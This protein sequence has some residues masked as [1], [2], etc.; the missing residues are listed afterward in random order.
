MTH[1]PFSKLETDIR[2]KITRHLLYDTPLSIYLF[3]IEQRRNV[4]MNERYYKAI[5]YT[6]QEF[7]SLGNN[8]L[9][10]MIPPD[11]FEN[12]YRF[13]DELTNSPN[14]DSHI[15]VHR[16]VCK[17]GS[18]K[19]FKNYVTVFEREPSGVPK[20]VLGIGIEVTFQVEARQK[21]FEQIK[22]IEKVSFTLSHE[23]RHEHSKILSILQFSKDNK[24]MIEVDDLQWLANSLYESAESIDKSIYSI[25]QQ[26]NS[27]KSEFI[28]LNSNSIE[29]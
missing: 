12:L 24:D 10:A 13:L 9:E 29:V 5:G 25:S 1:T 27:I 20:L 8:F 7:E 15:L 17:D 3:D 22:N 16:C 11:D 4:F 18:Y 2:S 21:L 26:L 14:D 19:W 6:A 23:L 28:T